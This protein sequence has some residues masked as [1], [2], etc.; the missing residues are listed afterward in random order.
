MKSLIDNDIYWG[1]FSEKDMDEVLLMLSK[2]KYG[3]AKEYIDKKLKRTEF[4]F[5]QK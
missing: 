5:L 3:E 1:E 4:I 2:D